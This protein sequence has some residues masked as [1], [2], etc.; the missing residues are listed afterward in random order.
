VLSPE[1]LVRL[2]RAPRRILAPILNLNQSS[3]TDFLPLWG[4]K[5]P[6]ADSFSLTRPLRASLSSRFRLTEPLGLSTVFLKL[7]QSLLLLATLLPYQVH[8]HRQQ[9]FN[10]FADFFQAAFGLRLAKNVS[11]EYLVLFFLQEVFRK[12]FNFFSVTLTVVSIRP[13]PTYKEQAAT[14]RYSEIRASVFRNFFS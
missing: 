10:F 2:F 1:N 13:T 8:R 6:R 3:K 14:I 4:T 9:L 12:K 5:N 7:F 11:G